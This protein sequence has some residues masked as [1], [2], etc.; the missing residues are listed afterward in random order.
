VSGEYVHGDSVPTTRPPG[1]S[2]ASC[3]CIA[4]QVLLVIH[5]LE[6]VREAVV[7]WHLD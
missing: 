7:V 6:R 3:T 2:T 4:R 5:R 1:S